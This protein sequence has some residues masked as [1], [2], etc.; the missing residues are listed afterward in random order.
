[1]Q[2]VLPRSISGTATY[3]GNA[4]SDALIYL[5][6]ED[7]LYEKSTHTDKDGNYSFYDI[8]AGNYTIASASRFYEK[9]VIN[10]TEDEFGENI[11]GKDLVL[12]SVFENRSAVTVTVK[13]ALGAP[14]GGAY[15]AA[16][17]WDADVNIASNT[18]ENG[19]AVVNVPYRA[20][21]SSYRIYVN[22]NDYSTSEYININSA[23][24]SVEAVMPSKAI[25]HG[26][27]K[28]GEIAAAGVELIISG[29]GYTT[30]TK[31][32]AEGKFDAEVY[33]AG[34]NR[35]FIVYAKTA[36]A[37]TATAVFGEDESETDITLELKENARVKGSIKDAA[38]R[39]ITEFSSLTFSGDDVY[40]T[41][42]PDANGEFETPNLFSE[43]TYSVYAYCSWPYNYKTISQNFDITEDD[44]NS[45][46]KELNLVAETKGKA[47]VFS[48]IDNKITAD[49]N[50][51][52]K[53]ETVTIC[54]KIKNDG[55]A[56]L[57]DV[58][59][60]AKLPEGTAVAATNGNAENGIV[61]KTIAS[62]KADENA[63]LTFTLN[64]DNFDGRA[65]T[66][67][68]FVK[69]NGKEY[70]V[71]SA[72]VEVASVTLSAP[73]VV[74]TGAAFKVSGEAMSGST[75]EILNYNTKAVLATTELTS[76]WYFADVPG[77]NE[78]TTI[79][80]RVSKNGKMGYSEPTL[81]KVDEN[82]I[83]VAD[84][85]VNRTLGEYGVNKYYGYH[86]FSMWEG[87][88]FDIS[89]KFNN[90]PDGATVKYSFMDRKDVSAA[91]NSEDYYKGTIN[92]WSGY[93]TKK[94]IATVT[95]GE[96]EY[97]FIVAEVIILID[98]SGYIIDSETG[99]PVVGA[100]V[101][102]EV[103]SGDEWI[104]WDAT[105]H[106][107]QNPMLTDEEGHYGWMV[108]EGE[109]RII[110]SADGYESKTVETYNSRD[111]GDNSKITVLPVRTDVDIALVNIRAAEINSS[112]T[113]SVAG[114]RVK[115]VF[116]RPVDPTTVTADNL[117]VLNEDGTVV[118]GTITLAENN[119]VAIFK[120][121]AA[122]A[123]GQYKLSVA[124]IKD[125]KGNTIPDEEI[126]FEKQAD[127]AALAA[128]TAAYN[129]D[130]T[131][132]VTFAEGKE[133]VNIE[134]I[135]VKN[136]DAVVSGTYRKAGNAITFIPDVAF[137]ASTSYNVVISDALRTADGEY[138][139]AAAEL[140]FTSGGS[141]PAT[142]GG[143]TG[144]GG[145]GTSVPKPT[146]NILP[147]EVAPGTKVELSTTIKNAKIYYTTDGS[148][149]TEKSTLYTGAITI[150]EDVV[151]K[152]IA[153][154]DKTK[155]A[156]VTAEYKVKKSQ[157][158]ANKGK[159]ADTASYEWAVEAINALAEKGIIKGVSDTE[160]APAN[161]IKRADFMLLLV[162][163]LDLKAD[164][165]DNFDD[166][167]ADSY[168]YEG[169]GIA[170]A[171]GLTDGVGGNKFMPEES[172]SRQDMFVM[173]YRIL[174]MQGVEL[175]A[176]DE[177]A[178]SAFDDYSE[179]ADY[180]REGL[181]AL[182]KNELVKGADNRINSLGNATRAETAVF[183]FR[184]C[185]LFNK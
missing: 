55:T 108:P 20:G 166:V 14:V 172:I 151:I 175:A 21:G 95:D 59:A 167:S 169:V 66:V 75:V 122:M 174:Q 132:T 39:N 56:A 155:S 94:V 37:G 44:I 154:G 130:G 10:V 18:N 112:E 61:S 117:K 76:K 43:G 23:V 81:I 53:G 65:L 93:G 143:T 32:D 118:N 34:G 119:T 31:T 178:I 73:Q 79:I 16:Y 87:Y 27:A 144:G 5:Y 135:I 168:Y 99:G 163:M 80:A 83:S 52:S 114:G 159:F 2:V 19:E 161:N 22:H 176:S 60:Y 157:E 162:R 113:A 91:K 165:N 72:V 185:N 145:G 105:P 126:S 183:V 89:A 64:T 184:L 1:M 147:G 63:S 7:G 121:M 90:L 104:K 33:L 180:A 38:A 150:N 9:S 77:I 120:P 137:A 124:N 129:S 125:G 51:I 78:D 41:V 15:V 92:N 47:T 97:E 67:P 54:V 88:S 57:S 136:G 12:S 8:A 71:G 134:E 58:T 142:P 177:S 109:Y 70:T 45:G 158:T 127:A 103:K 24:H 140:N 139:A 148:E 128:P 181:A 123:N 164:V 74:K 100:T 13:D 26:A 49:A 68:A 170:K 160:F 133:P 17:C 179:I 6:N 152:Y 29:N 62:M 84:V 30:Y 36:Y 149:P 141:A 85:K 171:L 107:Q 173:A 28:F 82:P 35:E 96:D 86:T 42:T 106:L 110:V 115:F 131:V 50:V 11:T 25:I 4:V 3:N 98:P 101:L 111:Y 48:G 138:L 102:L 40:V 182:V 153:I 116:T 69:A 146:A 156:V 46:I